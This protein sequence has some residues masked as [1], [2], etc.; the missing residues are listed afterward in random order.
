MEFREKNNMANYV[1]INNTFL[2]CVCSGNYPIHFICQHLLAIRIAISTIENK[3]IAAIKPHYE[4][5]Y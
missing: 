5:I 2:W 1:T 3:T 4:A